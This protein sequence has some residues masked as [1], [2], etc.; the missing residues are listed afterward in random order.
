MQH[1]RAVGRLHQKAQGKV[2]GLAPQFAVDEI[3]DAAG[4]QPEQGQRRHEV[5]HVSHPLT[6]APRK[7]G[8]GHHHTGE[9][10]VERH[11]AFPDT[12]NVVPVFRYTRLPV[13]QQVANSPAQHHTQHGVE[14]DVVDLFRRPRGAWQGRAQTP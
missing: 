9:A 3:A 5:E 11:A 4:T 12:P 1:L 13:K 6:G 7:P 10:A 2:G 8:N 14:N